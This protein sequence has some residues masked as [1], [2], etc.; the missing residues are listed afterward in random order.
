MVSSDSLAIEK[1]RQWIERVV[2]GLNLCPFARPVVDDNSLRIVSDAASNNEQLFLRALEEL[3]RLQSTAAS[4]ISTTL[5]VFTQALHDFQQYLDFVDML[6]QA[7][8]ET[9]L[10]GIVQIASFHPDYCFAEV[11]EDDPANFSNRS[12][13]P[14]VHFIRE[15][16]L[17]RAIL[18]Y[19]N[20]EQIPQRNIQRLRELGVAAIEDLIKGTGHE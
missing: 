5:L 11:D 6:N 4:E 8:V 9:G 14:M 17:E 1:T 12:P 7:L 13:Y 18:T 15:D 20:P 2:I 3:N 16:E 10:E 19:S